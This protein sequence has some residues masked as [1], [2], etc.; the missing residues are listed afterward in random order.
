MI[1]LAIPICCNCPTKIRKPTQSLHRLH[2]RVFMIEIML[3]CLDSV[4]GCSENSDN[5]FLLSLLVD[6]SHT[7][8]FIQGTCH[9][10]DE[11]AMVVPL[12]LHKG[13]GFSFTIYGHSLPHYWECMKNFI[14]ESSII[15]SSSLKTRHF[16][17]INT[18]NRT[19][20]YLANYML[21]GCLVG[22]L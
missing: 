18:A 4:T 5:D 2:C 21:Y 1:Y 6:W 20:R 11:C 22:F 15:E 7:P 12:L 19:I 9:G 8:E 10:E 16:S 14:V 17:G 13:K 3:G